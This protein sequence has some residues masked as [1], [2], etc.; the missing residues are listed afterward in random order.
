MCFSKNW[1]SGVIKKEGTFFSQDWVIG[2]R[3]AISFQVFS[4]CVLCFF[5]AF[6][7]INYWS[8]VV[9]LGCVV[10]SCAISTFFYKLRSVFGL[11]SAFFFLRSSPAILC[12]VT[13]VVERLLGKTI[14]VTIKSKMGRRAAFYLFYFFFF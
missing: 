12:N 3:G 6:F 1:R 10:N 9:C 8:S 5:F 2:S 4:F 11:L 14:T 13:N 7:L